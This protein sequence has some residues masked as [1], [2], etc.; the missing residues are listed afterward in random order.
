MVGCYVVLLDV[1]HLSQMSLK[2]EYFEVA[3]C[4]ESFLGD[5]Y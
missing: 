2:V 5:V 3:Q 4:V 1:T